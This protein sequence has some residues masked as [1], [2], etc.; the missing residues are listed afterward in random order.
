MAHAGQTLD[1]PISGE[2]ITFRKTAADTNGELLAIDLEL[3]PDGHVPGMHVH[4][5]QEETFE[6]V[7]GRMK[8]RMGMKKIIAEAGDVVTVPAGVAHKFS[9]AGEETAYVRVEVRPALRMEELF[10]TATQLAKDGRTNQKGMPKPLDLAL[11]TREF[12]R[13]VVAPFP[14][15]WVQRATLAPLAAIAERRGLAARYEAPAALPAMA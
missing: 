9:N 14:P 12:R 2:R 15:V 5:E 3:A 1:N 10:E 8:F 6:V 7:S 4:P 11:F 13:E